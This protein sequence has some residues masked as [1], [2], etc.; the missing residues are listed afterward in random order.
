MHHYL[1]DY[2]YIT[3]S[4]GAKHC[5]QYVYSL[6]VCL[7][8]YVSRK[9]HCVYVSCI[10]VARSSFGG[11]CYTLCTSGFVD[12]ITFILTMGEGWRL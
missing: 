6:F 11:V 2:S 5:Y 1:V 10:D 7:S 4:M 8:T 9:P 12:D 3:S